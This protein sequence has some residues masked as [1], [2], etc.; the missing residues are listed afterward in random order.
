MTCFANI[1]IRTQTLSLSLVLWTMYIFVFGWTLDIRVQI[2][3]D[4]IVAGLW[5]FG[6]NATLCYK[7]LMAIKLLIHTISVGAKS[8]FDNVSNGR[9]QRIVK[10]LPLTYQ[11]EPNH[12]NI[13]PRE[14]RHRIVIWLSI[15]SFN[16]CVWVCDYGMAFF[17]PFLW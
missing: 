12:R 1:Q 6:L 14:Y 11:T 8:S 17:A 9:K 13:M 3:L 5:H 16:V 2:S 4:N 7:T 10:R 15:Y